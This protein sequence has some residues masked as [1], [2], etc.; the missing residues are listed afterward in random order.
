MCVYGVVNHQPHGFNTHS[1]RHV[2]EVT[3]TSGQ[4]FREHSQASHRTGGR[5]GFVAAGVVAFFCE[6]LKVIIATNHD[7]RG[8]V[9]QVQRFAN[10]RQVSSI[11]RHSHRA[12]R[13]LVHAGSRGVTFSHQQHRSG[14][15]I[16]APVPQPGL[17]AALQ[18][19]FVGA[20]VRGF[21]GGN[22]LQVPQL[23]RR[24]NQGHQHAAIRRKPHAIRLNALAG[25][26]GA[27]A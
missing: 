4:T 8:R 2:V 11:K 21:A 9:C 17:A 22:A 3:G 24:V 20:T 23:A 25:Q 10:M 27:C 26:V 7:Q 15:R 16:T 12:A 18:K 19:Q 6:R 14:R 13:G 1:G 5:R